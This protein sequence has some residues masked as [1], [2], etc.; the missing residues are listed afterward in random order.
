MVILLTSFSSL[1]FFRFRIYVCSLFISCIEVMVCFLI[2]FYTAYHRTILQDD[3]DTN[4]SIICPG[5]LYTNICSCAA[6][7]NIDL[8]SLGSRKYL[9]G[10][11]ICLGVG[12]KFRRTE[13]VLLC[14]LQSIP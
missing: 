12:G 1:T 7:Y 3:F 11:N 6:C 9:N 13:V 4:N 10:G 14:F 8:F 2:C 5:F